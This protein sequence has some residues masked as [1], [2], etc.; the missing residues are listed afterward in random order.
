MPPCEGPLAE[1]RATGAGVSALVADIVATRLEL[2]G[3]ETGEAVIRLVQAVLLACLAGGLTV[4]GLGL[5]AIAVL[6]AVPPHWRLA[7]AAGGAAVALVAAVVFFLQLRRS[8]SRAGEL[9]AASIE[10]LKKDKAC[11]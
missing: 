3:L 8:L 1:L 6:L 9:F 2:L 11:F 4:V 10:E 7:T 5:G